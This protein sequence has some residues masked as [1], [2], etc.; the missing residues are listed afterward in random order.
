MQCKKAG[1][2]GIVLK[3]EQNVCLDKKL[4]F[5][6]ANKNKIFIIVK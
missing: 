1:M 6:L 2:K 3:S 5:K 4:L